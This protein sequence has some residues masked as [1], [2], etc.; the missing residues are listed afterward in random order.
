M[1]TMKEDK[2]LI[3][4]EQMRQ[5]ILLAAIDIISNEGIGQVSAAKIA[6]S[7]GTSKSN[8]FHHFN[9]K[10]AILL[11]VHDFI[12]EGFEMSFSVDETDL[13]TYLDKLG[14]A[15]FG[16]HE[17]MR[18]YKAF[19]AFYNEGLFVETFRKRL[20]ESTSL[21]LRMIEH[22]LSS[23]C[24]HQGFDNLLI[25]E[26]IKIVS[27]GILCFLDG[28]GL[29]HMLNPSLTHLDD[30]WKMQIEFWENYLYSK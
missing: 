11:G 22:Q 12:Y 19:Y 20:E 6:A 25:K 15:L 2:R 3:K 14:E 8:I 13:K 29:H 30:V 18:I 27:L 17:D 26:R 10:E 21:L 28:G 4:G 16:N 23:I 9:T 7:I 1:D 24:A 5:S